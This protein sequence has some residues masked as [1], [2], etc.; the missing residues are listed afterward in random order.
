[1]LLDATAATVVLAASTDTNATSEA[2]DRILNRIMSSL[3]VV[4]SYGQRTPSS[5][6]RADRQKSKEL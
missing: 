1:M 2:M 3:V 5:W 6:L 4:T